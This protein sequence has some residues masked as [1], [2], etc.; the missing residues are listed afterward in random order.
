MIAPLSGPSR[1]RRPPARE[2]G[3]GAPWASYSLAGRR[4]PGRGLREFP[5]LGSGVDPARSVIAALGGAVEGSRGL[6]R[7]WVTMASGVRRGGDEVAADVW[8]SGL[9]AVALAR[10]ASNLL[11]PALQGLL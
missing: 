2:V 7:G 3:E 6:T 9:S 11:N 5:P 4:R 1:A 8:P 10:G